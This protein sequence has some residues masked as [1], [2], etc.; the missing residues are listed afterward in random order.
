MTQSASGP[1]VC[2]KAKLS[3]TWTIF[4]LEFANLEYG[5]SFGRSGYPYKLLGHWSLIGNLNSNYDS[6][7]EKNNCTEINLSIFI[8]FNF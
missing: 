5:V 1:E 3:D 4:V 2:V 8:W 6:Y 7:T